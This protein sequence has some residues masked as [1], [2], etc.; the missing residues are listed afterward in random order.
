MVNKTMSS[1]AANETP[2]DPPALPSVPIP[3][4]CYITDVLDKALALPLTASVRKPLCDA[5][6]DVLLDYIARSSVSVFLDD[7][8]KYVPT[9]VMEQKKSA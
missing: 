5:I 8:V 3:E 2:A 4:V 1:N 9:E 6:R 7:N